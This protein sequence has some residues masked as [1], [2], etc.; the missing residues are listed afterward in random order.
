MSESKSTT[1]TAAGSGAGPSVEQRQMFETMATMQDEHNCLVHPQWRD[2][3]YDYYRAIWVECAELLDHFGWK[4]WKHQTP[5]MEQ[6]RLEL[7]DIW[8]FGLS[9]LIRDDAPLEETL[10]ALAA[11]SVPAQER[12]GSEAPLLAEASAE[13]FRAAVEALA[14]QTLI[15]KAFP[16]QEFVAALAALPMSYADLFELYIGKNVLNRFRQTHGY[17]E[18][19]YRKVWAAREDNEHLME[20]LAEVPVSTIDYVNTLFSRLEARYLLPDNA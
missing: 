1:E 20:V 12:S 5:D 2:Q 9:E 10:A 16:L 15:S 7:V 17:K 14:A 18:G 13:A 3:G 6:S 8:H 11:L 4:W 19:T